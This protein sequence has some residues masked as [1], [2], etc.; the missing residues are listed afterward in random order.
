MCGRKLSWPNLSYYPGIC[1]EGLKRNTIMLSQDSRSPRR[2]LNPGPSK[3][4]AEVLTTL[5][6][7]SALF[8]NVPIYTRVGNVCVH[9]HPMQRLCM[10]TGVPK[11]NKFCPENSHLQHAGHVA[12]GLLPNLRVC[13]LHCLNAH[14]QRAVSLLKVIFTVTQWKSRGGV[15]NDGWA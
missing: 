8:V 14:E 3:Y 6:R 15:R 7:R 1:Q 12:V 10:W 13:A 11:I 2:D 9:R 4:E 5:P